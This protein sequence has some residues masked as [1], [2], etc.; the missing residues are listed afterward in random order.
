MKRIH[1][2]SRASNR[3]FKW[4]RDSTPRRPSWLPRKFE[5]RRQLTTRITQA[6][7][8]QATWR[9]LT[10]ALILIAGASLI[11]YFTAR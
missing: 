7:R 3:G 6:T 5:S 8:S 9:A 4:F 11:I 10:L 1:T 2:S